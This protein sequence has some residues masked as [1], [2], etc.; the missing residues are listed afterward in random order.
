MPGEAVK[1]PSSLTPS[2]Q[3]MLTQAEVLLAS[4]AKDVDELGLICAPFQLSGFQQVL[5]GS[6]RQ[7][8]PSQG[9][10]HIGLCPSTGALGAHPPFAG[11]GLDGPSA[12]S[13]VPAQMP[14]IPVTCQVSPW[15]PAPPG[16]RSP[17]HLLPWCPVGQRWAQPCQ[18]QAPTTYRGLDRWTYLKQN[19]KHLLEVA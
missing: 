14:P 8:S 6:G 1:I 12:T 10:A 7:Q 2:S 16:P 9:A 3:E 13:P 15:H 18:A 4:P 5:V 19:D 17:H 11:L